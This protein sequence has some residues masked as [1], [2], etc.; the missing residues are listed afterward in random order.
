MKILN[1]HLL[2]AIYLTMTQ[3]LEHNFFYKSWV[4]FAAF[5]VIALPRK[6]CRFQKTIIITIEVKS[7]EVRSQINGM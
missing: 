3:I 7:N 5:G 4:T 6:S 2:N 1:V